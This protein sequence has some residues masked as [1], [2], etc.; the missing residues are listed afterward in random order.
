MGNI[1]EDHPH[2]I[3]NGAVVDQVQH[4]L[5]WYASMC[6]RSLSINFFLWFFIYNSINDTKKVYIREVV[7]YMYLNWKRELWSKSTPVSV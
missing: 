2:L 3:T 6:L 1:G 5:S 7:Y 4:Q